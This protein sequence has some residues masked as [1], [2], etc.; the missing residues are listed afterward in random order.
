M[1]FS[2]LITSIYVIIGELRALVKKSNS[3]HDPH[4]E[5]YCSQGLIALPQC[6]LFLPFVITVQL[7]E[8]N[9]AFILESYFLKLLVM[10]AFRF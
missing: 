6:T 9:N 5:N 10:M 8:I 1:E 2:K 4:I 3:S 7:V